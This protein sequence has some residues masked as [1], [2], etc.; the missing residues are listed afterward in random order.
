MDEHQ[1]LSSREWR[2]HVQD[3]EA[4]CV[5]SGQSTR[6]GV[7]AKVQ[8]DCVPATVKHA[9]CPGPYLDSRI[10]IHCLF[11]E[12]VDALYHS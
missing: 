8:T 10:S 7:N 3:V 9:G 5:V 2:V 11:L 4:L 6:F 1:S 12:I